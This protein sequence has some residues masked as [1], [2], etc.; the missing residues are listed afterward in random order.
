MYVYKIRLQL[1]LCLR[2][3]WG[4]Y[5]ALQTPYLARDGLSPNPG[6]SPSPQ[7]Y[8]QNVKSV[9]EYGKHNR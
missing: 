1:G 9:H 6:L 2:S 5:D 4:V 3:L 8:T 7:Y